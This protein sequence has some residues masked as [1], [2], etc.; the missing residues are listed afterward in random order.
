MKF[1]SFLIILVTLGCSQSD[2]ARL[3]QKS[4]A[5]PSLNFAKAK[6][7]SAT[8]K[9]EMRLSGQVVSPGKM[10]LAFQTAGTIKN[11]IAKPGM[12]FKKGQLLA[13]LDSRDISLRAEAARFRY[14][15]ALNAKKMAERDYQIEQ[16]LHAQGIG[17]LV[18]FENMELNA[19]N[20]RLSV[21]MA[22]VDFRLAQKA[23]EDS[24]LLA[25]FDCVITKQFKS[26]GE[27]SVGGGQDGN[28]AYEIYET[29]SPEIRLQAPE[30]LLE[31]IHI[32]DKL[33][34]EIPAL[35]IKLAAK[36]IRY[37]PVISDQ[38]RNFL[39]IAQLNQ[40]DSRVVP[41]YFAEGILK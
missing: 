22:D 9:G 31:S 38:T 19:E 14:E 35:K 8:Q 17:S 41:G 30:G 6:S 11:L 13:E 26:L 5:L 34:V 23:L 10:L 3:P 29:S 12:F 36:I 16:K 37:V 7:P 32:G 2:K 28:T 25:P 20:A 18:Q 15:Q 40:P 21:R 39:V 24:R 1:V 33:E 4:P 27:S